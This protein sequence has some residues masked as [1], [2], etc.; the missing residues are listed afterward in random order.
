MKEI[1]S[2]LEK[3]TRHHHPSIVKECLD[4]LNIRIPKEK[5]ILVAGTNGKGST[6][7][8]LQTLLVS[9]R[10]NVGFFSSPHL[11]KVNERIKFNGRDISDDE[12]CKIFKAI[13]PRIKSFQ[14]SYFEYL[15]LMSAYYF[16]F[17][18]E[19][20]FAIFEVGLGGTL[21]ATNAILHDISV[22]TKL[23][24]EH[25]DVLGKGIK[26]IA[27]NKLG[28]ISQNNH[29]FHS[30]FPD[31][32]QELA[33]KI[34]LERNANFTEAQ[35]LDFY[36]KKSESYPSYFIHIDGNDY[37]LNLMGQRAVE[38]TSLALQ[39][40]K[41][42]IPEYKKYLP[43]LRSVIWPCR[44]EKIRYKGRDIFLSGDHNPQ[45]I[46]SLLEILG[47]FNFN[48]IYFV[49]GI[50]F[51]KDS[52][53]MINLL[54]SVKNSH[55]YLTETP[56]KTLPTSDYPNSVKLN[57][58]FTSKNPIQS[59]NSAI[60]NSSEQDLIVI[61]GSLYLAGFIKKQATQT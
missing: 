59:L 18:K 47:N 51:D 35:I 27:K 46:Q 4:V 1:L 30:K 49:V 50:C 8:T 39:V 28:I 2:F 53:K 25:E 17:I 24:L 38:N 19:I 5:L 13:H 26:S 9:A 37:E 48:S 44:M 61:T 29:V 32:V 6:C 7:A 10:K 60:E 56:E 40:F 57:A 14:L 42:L 45:G 36:V 55:I 33:K 43:A 15:T 54:R 3:Q 52:E 16:Y 31:E 23:G 20:D 12:F 21:D 41:H 11:I 34:Q 58:E 22:I